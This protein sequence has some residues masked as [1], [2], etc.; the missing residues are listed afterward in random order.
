MEYTEAYLEPCQSS[1]IEV[2]V[3]IGDNLKLLTVFPE[4]SIQDVGQNTTLNVLII[5]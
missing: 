3:K 4:N 5:I 1:K 2:F